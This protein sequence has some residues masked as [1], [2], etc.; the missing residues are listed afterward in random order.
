ALQGVVHTLTLSTNVIRPDATGGGAPALV[1]IQVDNG[2][3]IPA[4]DGDNDQG[5]QVQSGTYYV[6]VHTVDG[7]GGEA[8]LT[9]GI[10]VMNGPPTAG[11]VLATP[12]QLA[13]PYPNFTFTV[14]PAWAESVVDVRIYDLA[15]ELITHF[16]AAPQGGKVSWRAGRVASGLYLAVVTLKT[17]GG[18]QLARETLRLVVLQ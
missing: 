5:V 16:S 8:T 7:H 9:E 13:G 14:A 18:D 17:A 12:N 1:A 2:L 3:S 4:W 6:A 10:A 15:G 11:L